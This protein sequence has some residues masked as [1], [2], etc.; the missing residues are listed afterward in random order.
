M[1]GPSVIRNCDWHQAKAGLLDCWIVGLLDCWI[2]GLL[3]YWMLDSRSRRQ[4]VLPIVTDRGCV[5]GTSRNVSPTQRVGRIP[6]ALRA[7]AAAAGASHT[8]ALE[9]GHFRG[10]IPKGFRLKA[11]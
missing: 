10:P 6:T 3:D 1:S 9:F 4:R 7:R 8:A 5:Q 2:I 11:Q